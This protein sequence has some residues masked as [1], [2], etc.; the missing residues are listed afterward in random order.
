MRLGW[1]GCKRTKRKAERDEERS[2]VMEQKKKPKLFSIPLMPEEVQEE[3][4]RHK[5]SSSSAFGGPMVMNVV[6]DWVPQ[7]SA[8][9]ASS[10]H[11]PAA[12]ALPANPPP[13]TA[14]QPPP[15]AA[16]P[17]PATTPIRRPR[18]STSVTQTPQTPSMPHTFQ[19]ALTHAAWVAP[20]EP[21]SFIGPFHMCPL[22]GQPRARWELYWT[23]RSG[24]GGGSG[25]A[26]T[27]TAA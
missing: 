25:V 19:S 13:A 18:P 5:A 23:R 9:P 11:S 15:P 16:I 21:T 24:Q 20:P 10:A 8:V 14:S 17:P 3:L 4:L 22:C 26:I 27:P 7:S 6:G 2:F 12:A 1:K